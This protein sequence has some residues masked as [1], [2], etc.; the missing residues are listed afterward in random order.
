MTAST[1]SPAL[2]AAMT[3]TSK[4]KRCQG[5]EDVLAEWKLDGGPHENK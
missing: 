2:M 3:V 5:A 4:N 1:F